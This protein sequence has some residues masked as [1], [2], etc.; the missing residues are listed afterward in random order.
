MRK[1]LFSLLLATTMLVASCAPV[2]A[3]ENGNFIVGEPL[4]WSGYILIDKVAGVEYIVMETGHM[5]GG[6]A[7]TPRLNADGSLFTADHE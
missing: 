4:P 3:T 5:H 6:M 1:L 2:H 7:I